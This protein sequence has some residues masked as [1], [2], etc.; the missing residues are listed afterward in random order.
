MG[1]LKNRKTMK[2]N[3]VNMKQAKS[4]RNEPRVEFCNS[5][6]LRGEITKQ[7]QREHKRSA[8]GEGKAP[9]ELSDEEIARNVQ[10]MLSRKVPMHTMSPANS[11]PLR[12]DSPVRFTVD[13]ALEETFKKYHMKSQHSSDEETDDDSDD[14]YE[15]P[16]K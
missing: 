2:S 12:L 10:A 16:K 6:R 14:P 13:T 7:Q 15:I 11:R 8:R 3:S 1:S 5:A 9:K 4:S